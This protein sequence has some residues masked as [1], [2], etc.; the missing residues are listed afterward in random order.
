[1]LKQEIAQLVAGCAR[2]NDETR[3]GANTIL[4][5]DKNLDGFMNNI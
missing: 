5:M 3:T 1:M 4:A 2:V